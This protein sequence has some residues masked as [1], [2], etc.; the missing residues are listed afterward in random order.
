VVIGVLEAATQL[1]TGAITGMIDR[2]ERAGLA[3][4]ERVAQDRR[5]VMV[6]LA[7]TASRGLHLCS[8]AGAGRWNACRRSAAPPRSCYS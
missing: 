1:T 5:K 2:L 7:P 4:S 3:P 8:K 6:E